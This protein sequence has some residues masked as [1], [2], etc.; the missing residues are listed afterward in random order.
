MA[1]W[2]RARRTTTIADLQAT[3]PSPRRQL[4]SCQLPNHQVYR[5]ASYRIAMCGEMPADLSIAESPIADLQIVNI[6]DLS[7]TKMPPVAS[8]VHW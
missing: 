4:P 7:H 6:T 1:G 2:H 8:P 5:L 3:E